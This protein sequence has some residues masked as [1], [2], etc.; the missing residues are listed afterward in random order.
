MQFYLPTHYIL[1]GVFWRSD[2]KGDKE[3]IGFNRDG[4]GEEEMRE[5]KFRFWM[6]NVKQM[7]IATP[8]DEYFREYFH[9][10]SVGIMQYTGLKDKN[11]KEIY[12]GDVVKY[13]S[14]NLLSAEP[15]VIEYKDK[16]C[17]FGIEQ[18][19]QTGLSLK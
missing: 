16:W 19:K 6:P 1:F 7:I 4:E 5:I 11:G 17:G 13:E 8:L 9:H 18:V 15:F 2:L 12:E 14:M 10:E 3:G